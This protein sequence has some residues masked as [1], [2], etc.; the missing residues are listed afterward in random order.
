LLPP[1]PPPATTGAASCREEG[2][3]AA[4]PPTCAATRL[5]RSAVASPRDGP[6]ASGLPTAM[7]SGLLRLDCAAALSLPTP[8]ANADSRFMTCSPRGRPH[9]TTS[10]SQWASGSFMHVSAGGGPAGRQCPDAHAAVRHSATIAGGTPLAGHVPTRNTY[11][12]SAAGM[13]TT[14][15]TCA[16]WAPPK[17]TTSPSLRPPQHRKIARHSAA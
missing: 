9:V 14:V 10:D 7:S 4:P 3:V 8:S 2:L 16:L 12:K 13:F 17:Q 5:L 1:L 11:T 6:P 15:P